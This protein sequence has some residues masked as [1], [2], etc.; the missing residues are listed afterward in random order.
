M[1]Q[2]LISSCRLD[3]TFC[4][5]MHSIGTATMAVSVATVET[6]TPKK[7]N[8]F[9]DSASISFAFS[10]IPASDEDFNISID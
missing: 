9:T 7:A 10:S 4:M 3:C 6:A 2:K 1:R 8:F 5:Y